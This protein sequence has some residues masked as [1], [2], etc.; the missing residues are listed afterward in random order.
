M[1]LSI[2]STPEAWISLVTLLFLEIVLGV[3]NIVFIIMTTDRLPARLQPIGRKL[4]L[5]GAFVSR[6]LFLCFASFLVSMTNPLLTVPV[7]GWQPSLRDLVLALGGAYLI[8]KGV[9]ELHVTLTLRDEKAENDDGAPRK[10]IGLAGAVATIMVMDIVFSIDSVITA[11][12][13]ADHLIIMIAAVMLA[14]ILMMVFIDTIADFI[15]SHIEMTI[16]ALTFIVAIGVLLVIDGLGFHTGIEIEALGISLEKA[17]VYFGMVF[18]L[19]MTLLQ[20][21]YRSNHAKWVAEQNQAMKKIVAEESEPKL[22]QHAPRVSAI[23]EE[24]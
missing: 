3:D 7:I 21:R 1:D 10:S 11:V 4:G 20:M 9:T 5:L 12:G 6:A 22:P 8:Y 2:F 24:E 14:I 15:N 13:L 23:K 19:V 17:M 18:S 16:L